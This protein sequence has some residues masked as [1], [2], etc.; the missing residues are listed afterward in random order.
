MTTNIIINN[1]FSDAKDW[2]TQAF[3]QYN[4]FQRSAKEVVPGC[5]LNL[6]VYQLK[7]VEQ[8]L[9][10][11]QYSLSYNITSDNGCC[12]SLIKYKLYLDMSPI[13]SVELSGEE[14]LNTRKGVHE[15]F[16]DIPIGALTQG[17]YTLQ[18]EFIGR[19]VPVIKR[20]IMFML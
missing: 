18:V 10:S 12:Y 8:T 2:D 5:A 6:T 15:L 1:Q 9:S 3:G 11:I 7:L 14:I 19:G 17:T 16:F 4:L 13:S 20:Y